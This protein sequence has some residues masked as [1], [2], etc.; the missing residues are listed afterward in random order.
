MKNSDR[1]LF[2]NAP[3]PNSWEIKNS[4]ANKIFYF[5]EKKTAKFFGNYMRHT[6]RA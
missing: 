4:K 3:F 2:F 6:L 5:I 1:Q